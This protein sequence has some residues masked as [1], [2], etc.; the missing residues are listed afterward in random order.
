MQI[1]PCGP[2]VKTGFVLTCLKERVVKA[3][4]YIKLG[5]ILLK[6]VL[7]TYLI[8]LPIAEAREQ[9]ARREELWSRR[10][11]SPQRRTGLGIAETPHRM[12]ST[13]LQR[14]DRALKR[15]KYQNNCIQRMNT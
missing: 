1:A 3:A 6:E 14:L 5:L 2:D 15:D 10:R 12:Q 8:P 4:P 9:V 13:Q 11:T 7:A